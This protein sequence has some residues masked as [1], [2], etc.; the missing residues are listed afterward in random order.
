MRNLIWDLCIYC[1]I[2]DV[3]S[4]LEER[5]DAVVSYID[6]WISDYDSEDE[7]ENVM[8]R[9]YDVH[10]G[11]KDYYCRFFFL[12]SEGEIAYIDIQEEN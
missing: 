8:G 9:S 10:I 6:E 5:L 12:A 2:D 11:N 4:I 1:D 3:K 7:D